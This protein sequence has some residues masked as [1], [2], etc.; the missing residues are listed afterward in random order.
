MVGR[1][2]PPERAGKHCNSMKPAGQR[3]TDGNRLGDWLTQFSRAC[4]RITS[5][6]DLDSILQEV[7][8]SAC[9]LTGA[10]YGALLTFDESGDLGSLITSGITAEERRRMGDPPKGLGVLGYLNKIEGSLRLPDISAHASSVGFPEN[11][12][13]MKTFL[14]SPVRFHGER[15]GNIY[16]TEKAGGR[17]FSQEDEEVL[18]MFASQSAIA[19][20]NSRVLSTARQARAD[21]E[22]LLNVSPVGVL[23]FDARTGDLVSANEETRRLVGD[24]NAPGPSIG[25]LLEVIAL[26]RPD[27]SDIPIDELPTMRVIRTGESVLADEIVIHL[28]DGRNITTLVNAR[29]VYGEDGNP[30][31]VVATIQDITPL[32][33]MKR[34][35]AEFLGNVSHE[36]RTPLSSI[37]G[38]T[39]TLLSAGYPPGPIE[40]RQFLRVIDEQAD[41]MHNLINDLVDMTQIEAGTLSVVPEPTETVDLLEEASE[42]RAR[43]GEASGSVELE[44]PSTLPRV[45]ADRR[46]IL[47]VL[48]NLLVEVS[49]YAAGSSTVRISASPGDFYVAV[50]V[51]NR[52]AGAAAGSPQ[53]QFSGFSRAADDAA[54]RANGTGHLGI[55]ICQGIVE[56]HGGR[57]YVE[58]GEE[59][60]GAGFTFTIPVADDAARPARQGSG[61]PAADLDSPGGQVRVLAIIENPETGR[62]L[63]STLLRAGFA[64]VVTS[65]PD[66]AERLIENRQPQLVILEPALARGEGFE[67]LM[68]VGGVTDAPVIVVAGHGWDQHIGRAFE[69]GA[70]D[71]I[72]K[73]F[74]SSE[75]L[76][77]AGVALRR[78][79]VAGWGEPSRPYLHGD[80]VIDYLEREVTV[81]GRPVNLTATE[82]KLLTQLSMAG[83]RVL[84]HEQL[85]RAVWGPLYSSDSRIVR[86]YV[87]ELRH[88]LGDDAV[89]PTYIFT[90]LGVG[91]RMARPATP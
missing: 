80:L 24:L 25:Q 39:A 36:L 86:T 1:V 42:G 14:G 34:Q 71:Y 88:K 31:S 81:S 51:E 13:P 53:E 72:A 47:Q 16:L 64:V 12:P 83:G 89:R 60:R 28:P 78:R 18:V 90:E 21:M 6:V 79:S 87:K 82:Y 76:A 49:G 17:E 56:A 70:S 58:N 50:T 35:R 22:A 2:R 66:E 65:D 9:A 3:N 46:R 63:R 11:H 44:L 41:R 33:E 37:K 55:P 26:R 75:L 23:V 61:R 91:Y 29:P 67:A 7:I 10:R 62:H 85:L 15:L 84:S 8:D 59:G 54:D 38:S 40:T 74:T 52:D 19:I 68:R 48:D 4:L 69:L 5:M 45:M 20:V 43:A 57:L 27:G 77:R 32:E 73:P 30:V